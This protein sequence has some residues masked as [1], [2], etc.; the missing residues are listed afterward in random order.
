MIQS[1]SWK[2]NG[3]LL[4]TSCKDKQ[5]R[6]IDPRASENI[7]AL[8]QSHQSIRDSRIVWLGNSDRILTTGFD[9]ARIRQ[10]YIRDL[11]NFAEP[12]KTIELDCSTG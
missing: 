9:A 4:S 7:V 8:C 2:Q 3:T 10:V 12:L 6:I 1:V 5:T 11:R